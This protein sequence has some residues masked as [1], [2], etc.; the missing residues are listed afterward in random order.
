M[1]DNI[2]APSQGAIGDIHQP[3]T[4]KAQLLQMFTDMREEI[5]KQQ[6][7]FDRKHEQAAHDRENAT[8]E[9][10]EMKRLK[11]QLLAQITALQ[12]T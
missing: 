1:E 4:Y 3:S 10:E 5:A 8:C 6:A 2:S 7:L 9:G 12:N 11:D